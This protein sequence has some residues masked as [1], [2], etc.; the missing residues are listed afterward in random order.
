[1]SQQQQANLRAIIKGH[2]WRERRSVAFSILSMLGL[3]LTELLSPW[4]LKIIF[5]YI[6]LDKHWPP[7][8]A[9]LAEVLANG[10]TTAIIIVS[11]GILLVAGLRS[12]FSYYQDYLFSRLGYQMVYTLR[13]ELFAHL[14]QLSLSFHARTRTGELLTKVVSDTSALKDVFAESAVNFVSH[15][16]TVVGM[17]AVM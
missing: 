14:Q 11:L 10:K 12:V 9:W 8:F 15:L 13:R 6:L 3:M 5:D 2:L 17:F 4:P 7:S 1:M 16:L